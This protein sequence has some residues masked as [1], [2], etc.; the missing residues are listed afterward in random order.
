MTD[1]RIFIDLD[2]TLCGESEWRGFWSNTAKLFGELKFRPPSLPWTILTA[3]PK[4]DL[5]VI[6]L[7]CVRHRLKPDN[8]ISSPSWLYKFNNTGE[9]IQWKY[10]VLNEYLSNPLISSVIYIDNDVQILECLPPHR[11]L[12]LYNTKSANE[13]LQEVE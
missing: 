12:K 5:P 6:K 11:R 1:A 9:V 2:G 4:I 7:V 13:F 8:I 3:R 10:R